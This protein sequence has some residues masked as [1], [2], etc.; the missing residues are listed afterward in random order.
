MDGVAT[1]SCVT[2]GFP[3]G[4]PL[5]LC[6]AGRGREAGCDAARWGL[7]SLTPCWASTSH[8]CRGVG[9]GLAHALPSLTRPAGRKPASSAWTAG[10]DELRHRL[11]PSPDEPNRSRP[12]TGDGSRRR[13]S[14][15]GP[16]RTW[17][18]AYRTPPLHTVD[19]VGRT[20]PIPGVDPVGRGP[21]R[22]ALLSACRR[23]RRTAQPRTRRP[24]EPYRRRSRSLVEAVQLAHQLRGRSGSWRPCL[25]CCR[26]R[27]RSPRSGPDDPRLTRSCPNAVVGQERYR[28]C[29]AGKALDAVC[30]LPRHTSL[31]AR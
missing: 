8:P 15:P 20:P 1:T 29:P 9:R 7:W 5:T 25:P 13:G 24:H 27:S 2:A 10:R 28:R 30:S 6:R 3:A 21:E 23:P 16:G 26:S 18:R 11:L 17:T 12:R 4:M 14:T 31:Y 19:P 22:T